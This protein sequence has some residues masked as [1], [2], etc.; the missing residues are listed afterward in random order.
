MMN[1][2]KRWLFAM[3]GSFAA[4]LIL[5]AAAANASLVDEKLNLERSI[6][7]RAERLVEKIIGSKDMV[8]LANVDLEAESV[9]ISNQ[10]GDFAGMQM[11]EEEYLPGITYSH[12]PFSTNVS[13]SKGVSIKKIVVLVTLDK[14]ASDATVEQ[15]KKEVYEL[16]GLDAI[17]NDA[18]NVKRIAFASP[19]ITW[20][21]YLER[22][23]T[24]FY[25]LLAILLLTSFLFGPLRSFF[26]RTT[27]LAQ[28]Q[29]DADMKR[30]NDKK[31]EQAGGLGSSLLSGELDLTMSRRKQQNT[32]ESKTTS[33]RFDFVT[34][35][36]IK[37]L[38]YLLKRDTIEKVAIVINFIPAEYASQVL[39]ALNIRQ[40]AQ[41]ASALSETKLLDPAAV[42]SV[43]KEIRQKIDYLSGG[44][45]YFVNLLDRS[46]RDTQEN[47]IMTLEKENAMLAEQLR[48][49]LFFFD[50]LVILEKSAVQKL[51]RLSQR[52]SVSLAV[53]LK[54]TSEEIRSKV[55]EALTEGARA[56][57][58]EQ[59]ELLG[60]IPEKRIL[61]E[62]RMIVNI[63]R[64]LEKDNEIIVDRSKKSAGSDIDG[65]KAV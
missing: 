30:D 15:I 35:D 2:A 21:N 3:A 32:D 23:Q 29:V 25:W 26:K 36:N 57:L 56:M 24:G 12:V 64:E 54:G 16:L 47:I 58:T 44:L 59:I 46:D 7:E 45:D 34:D 61:E 52:R 38:I 17:R 51:I 8:V 42:E 27:A 18:V 60:E 39:G 28:L 5:A 11:Q 49:S 50:D 55:M 43:E 65:S 48:N 53:A 40:Q 9:K 37:N 4:S 20:L 10:R 13:A 6:Q 33:K 14:K 63:V 22:Y 19:T 62:Q 31:S 41:I 1:H